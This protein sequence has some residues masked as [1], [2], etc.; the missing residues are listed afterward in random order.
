MT[1]T[2]PVVAQQATITLLPVVAEFKANFTNEASISLEHKTE[3]TVR[4]NGS[5]TK[6]A[7]GRLKVRITYQT[8]L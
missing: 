7:H 5:M 4:R 8:H 2:K 3:R 6:Q 1:S